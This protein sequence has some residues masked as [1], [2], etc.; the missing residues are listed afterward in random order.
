M[1]RHNTIDEICI[2]FSGGTDRVLGI[3]FLFTSKK[4]DF[5]IT[6]SYSDGAQPIH[7]SLHDK[8]ERHAEQR[9]HVKREK[10]P[11][12][13]K[14]LVFHNDI[15]KKGTPFRGKELSAGVFHVARLRYS[16]DLQRERFR[17]TATICL[18]QLKSDTCRVYIFDENLPEYSVVDFDIVLSNHDPF[19]FNQEDVFCQAQEQGSGSPYIELPRNKSGQFLTAT[20]SVRSEIDSPTFDDVHLAAP[21]ARDTPVL[22]CAGATNTEGVYWLY[23]TVTSEEFIGAVK[24]G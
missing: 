6:P 16:W 9:F 20:V 10:K 18:S 8:T 24:D 11:T 12:D 15:F 22:A 21:L 14:R 5:Y 13:I 2:A 19:Y 7:L 3:P 17:E 23:N 4:A 1:S